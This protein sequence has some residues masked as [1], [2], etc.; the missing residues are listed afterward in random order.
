[1]IGVYYDLTLF[2]AFSHS[3]S[4]SY[5]QLLH[6]EGDLSA[7]VVGSLLAALTD[8]RLPIVHLKHDVDDE[9]PI[10][11]QEI[12]IE[13]SGET[14]MNWSSDTSGYEERCFIIQY[15]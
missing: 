5:L 15:L 4:P 12:T 7:A 8:A 1:M 2:Y 9:A 6:S 14:S 11:P 13:V 10:D 3:L